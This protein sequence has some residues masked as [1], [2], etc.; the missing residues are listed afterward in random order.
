M[1]GLFFVRRLAG[2]LAALTFSAESGS[3]R[4]GVRVN[5]G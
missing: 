2:E 3:V 5:V 1:A 4:G